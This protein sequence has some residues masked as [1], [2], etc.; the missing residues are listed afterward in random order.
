MYFYEHKTND[1]FFCMCTTKKRNCVEYNL[2][3]AVEIETESREFEL[4]II[5]NFVFL[6]RLIQELRIF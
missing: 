5:I 1:N 6:Q 3:S 2:M 4:E